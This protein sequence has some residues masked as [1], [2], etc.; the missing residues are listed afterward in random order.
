VLECQIVVPVVDCRCVV[1]LVLENVLVLEQEIVRGF[2]R[3]FEI[4]T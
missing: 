4:W 2:G 1:D 3:D